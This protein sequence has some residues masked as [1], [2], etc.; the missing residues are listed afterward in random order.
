LSAQ[1]QTNLEG[2][3]ETVNRLAGELASLNR[4]IENAASK[5][6][7]PNDLLDRRDALLQDLSRYAEIRVS[8]NGGATDVVTLGGH[9]LVQGDMAET[10]TLHSD[11]AG[12]MS[13]RWAGKD[14]E[15]TPESGEL[16]AAFDLTSKTLPDTLSALDRI[17][18]G[19]SDR[20]NAVH[21]TGTGLDGGTGRDFFVGTGARDL[22]LNPELT[23]RPDRLGASAT[24]ARGD[25]SIALALARVKSEPGPDGI[26]LNDAYRAAV[27]RSAT[28]A[29]GYTRQ[30]D[31]QTQVQRQLTLRRDSV[32]GVNLD[33]EMT[34]MIKFQQ[35]YA[36]S[37]RVLSTM[38]EMLDTLINRMG[39]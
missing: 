37:A 28:E 39:R 19:L 21:R 12:T 3:V 24:G 4:E 1:Q 5:G 25:G 8:G 11:A 32:S 9:V 22:R 10:L 2:G 34:D 27:T 33:E 7:P 16:G 30:T 14:A 35:A 13:L 18:T 26:P 17:A 6:S 38:D 20:L 36:A 29:A 15:Y 31:V 23:D